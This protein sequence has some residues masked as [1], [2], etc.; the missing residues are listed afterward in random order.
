MKKWLVILAV[1]IVV[2]TALILGARSSWAQNPNVQSCLTEHLREAMVLNRERE[3]LYAELSQGQ[4]REVTEGLLRMERKLLLTAPLA[5]LWAAP[6][7]AAGIPLLCQDLISMS[8][9][10]SFVAMNP[11]GPDAFSNFIPADVAALE[12]QLNQFY[13]DRAYEDLADYLDH[14]IE[15]LEK[16]PR[17][18]CLVKHMLESIRRMAVLTPQH[19]QKAKDL[20]WI[21]PEILSRLV[22]KTN[23]GLLQASLDLDIMAA[24]LQ[25]KGVQIICQ[26][27]PAIPRP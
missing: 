27:V 2:V 15:K 23:I 17:Y 5:D 20:G 12:I 18:N 19:A 3:P 11:A 25:A 21:S 22:L 13:S 16:A 8:E 6:Y 14:E 1:V 26:D 4:S 9:T 7:Q 10:P 24:P